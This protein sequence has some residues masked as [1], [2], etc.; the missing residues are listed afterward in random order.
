MFSE[1]LRGFD[2]AF[3]SAPPLAPPLALPV[4]QSIHKAIV[5]KRDLIGLSFDRGLRVK[6]AQCSIESM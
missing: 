6:K 1:K 3:S 2:K 5:L 4:S